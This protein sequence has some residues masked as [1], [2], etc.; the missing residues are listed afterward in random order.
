MLTQ[1]TRIYVNN[2]R[3]SKRLIETH[4]MVS[5]SEK[6]TK[7]HFLLIKKRTYALRSNH[8]SARRRSITLAFLKLTIKHFTRSFFFVRLYSRQ[9]N[10]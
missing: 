10:T 6:Q 9:M 7:R 4:R 2:M 3:H 1:S 5:E 8:H